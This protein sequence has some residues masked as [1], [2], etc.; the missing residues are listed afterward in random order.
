MAGFTFEGIEAAI[1]AIAALK[2]IAGPELSK[3]V[4]KNAAELQKKEKKTVPV[5]THFLQ[6]SIFLAVDD[7]GMTAS[8][9]PTAKYA[10]YVEYGTRYMSAQP[11]VRP[12]YAEQKE[13]FMKDMKKYIKE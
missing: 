12:N 4:K 13:I 11:Y 5:D 3:V 2:H 9:V 7:N 1:K 6:H 10:G 8:V